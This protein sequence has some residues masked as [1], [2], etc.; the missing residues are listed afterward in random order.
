M[1]DYAGNV[2]DD[3]FLVIEAGGG[4]TPGEPPVEPPVESVPFTVSYT[5]NEFLF[6]ITIQANA[7]IKAAQLFHDSAIDDSIIKTSL[8]TVLSSTSGQFTQIPAGSYR[9]FISDYAGNV[10]ENYQLVVE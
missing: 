8:D 10:T 3:Y 4:S 6:D 7:D 2:V 1:S 5:A 9:L